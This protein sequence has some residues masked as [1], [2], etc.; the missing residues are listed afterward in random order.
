MHTFISEI[1]TLILFL[2]VLILTCSPILP[3]MGC[4]PCTEVKGV[5]TAI[6]QICSVEM[7]LS[8]PVAL[9]LLSL[10]LSASSL[11]DQQS[12]TIFF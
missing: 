9:F 5:T 7:F 12:T 10:A 4:E 2:F 3:V 8:F 6:Y 11:R 1:L